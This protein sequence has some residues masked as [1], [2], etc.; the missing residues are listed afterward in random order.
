MDPE[1]L[2]EQAGRYRRM[3]RSVVDPRTKTVLESM[4]QECELKAKAAEEAGTTERDRAASAPK[5]SR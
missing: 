3:M 4:A 2:R 1:T 5:L